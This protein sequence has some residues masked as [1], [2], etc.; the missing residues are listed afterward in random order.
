M[1]DEHNEATC[2]ALNGTI[3]PRE[4]MPEDDPNENVNPEGVVEPRWGPKHAGAK[5]LASLYSKEKRLQELICV[6]SGIVLLIIIFLSLLRHFTIRTLPS[7]LIAAFVGILMADFLSGLVHWAADSWGTI[8]SF[9]GKNFIRSFR[10]HH[11]DPTAITRHD[12]IECNGDNFMLII[13][14]LLHMLYQHLTYD[15]KELNAIIVSHWFYLLLSF[16]VALTNQIHKWSHTYFGLSPFVYKLQQL[17]IIL[18]RQHHRIHHV[19]PHASAY[20]ITTGW[21]NKPLDAI[22]FWRAAEMLITYTTGMKPRTDDLK[23]AKTR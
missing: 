18:P 19:S 12:L 10:E 15:E 17:N 7:I 11:V 6:V 4:A 5:Q 13:P 1:T 8:D 14:K 23:W 20:C 22:G 3:S 9:I 21:L 16:Y 2:K